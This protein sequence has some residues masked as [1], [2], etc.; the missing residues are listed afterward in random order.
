MKDNVVKFTFCFMSN[1]LES[2]HI[3]SIYTKKELQNE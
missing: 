3:L 1:E 2:Y